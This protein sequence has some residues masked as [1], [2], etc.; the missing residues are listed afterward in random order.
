MVRVLKLVKC[1]IFIFILVT[2]LAI[3]KSYQKVTIIKIDRFVPDIKNIL[4]WTK[5]HGLEGEGQK[6]FIDKKCEFINCYFTTNKSLFDDLRYF[7]VILFNLQ[8]VSSDTYIL[9]V[10][11]SSTQKY[12]FV[13]NDSSDNYPVCNVVYDDFFNWT[14]TYRFD[15]TISYRF[16]TVFNT[17][18]EELGS[19]FQWNN[20]MKPIDASLKSQFVT[21]SKAAVIF[22]DKCKSRSKREVLIQNLQLNLAKYNLNVDVFG[23]C[24]PKQCKRKT[25]NPCFWRL[26]KNY[27]FYLAFEDSFSYDYITEIVL[28]GYN[29]NAVPIVYGGAMYDKYLPPGS[30]INALN[31][32]SNALAATMYDIIKNKEKYYEFFRWRNHYIISRA[33]H[34]N[35]CALC[36]MLNSPA[37]LVQKVAYTKFRL[38]WN[39]LYKTRCG[40]DVNKYSLL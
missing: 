20:N 5:I 1:H 31:T 37:R 7:D 6:Y 13:A 3:L 38:W 21:K 11:R 14:W 8:D 32:T 35:A 4:F 16:I 17:E 34:L 24:G 40:S 26:R 33:P 23:V 27:Y 36:E 19:H 22:L 10:L 25:M 28:Y 39:H 29:N 30:Y 15:S 12:I 2:Y 18:Y 9:P